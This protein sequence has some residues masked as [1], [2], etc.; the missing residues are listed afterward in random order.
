MTTIAEM[1]AFLE[2]ERGAST[3]APVAEPRTPA[4]NGNGVSGSQ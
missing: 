3:M 4:F 1:G 2:R